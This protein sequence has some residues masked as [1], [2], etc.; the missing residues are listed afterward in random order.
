MIDTGVVDQVK[1]SGYLCEDPKDF[2]D[3]NTQDQIGHGTNVFGLITKNFSKEEVCVYSLK[4]WHPNI[5]TLESNRTYLKALREALVLK[6]DVL[7]LS[8]EGRSFFTQE[9]NIL[10]S[11][12]ASGT[13]VVTVAG[14][15]AQILDNN[16]CDVY[17]ACF[18]RQLTSIRV[19]GALNA[20]YSGKG[21]LVNRWKNGT[22]QCAFGIC[23]SGTSMAAANQ[24]NEEVRNLLNAKTK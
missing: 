1:T 22:N 6:P 9:Y 16:N 20:F 19:V 15:K 14:N 5:S 23:K 10:S 2:T 3:T 11:L 12:I 7:N 8:L 17:P 24:T 18:V 13:I 21:P 4:F